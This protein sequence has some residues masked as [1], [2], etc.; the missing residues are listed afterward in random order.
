MESCALDGV[1]VLCSVR[2][3]GLGV[4]PEKR[5]A[6]A[7]AL[8]QGREPHPGRS[9][10]VGFGL[11]IA[12]HLAALMDGTMW[13]ESS[14]GRGST[15]YFTCRFQLQRSPFRTAPTTPRSK[16]EN[17]HGLIVTRNA[18]LNE[19]LTSNLE[20]WSVGTNHVLNTASLL[21]TL[22]FYEHMGL[23][24]LDR[25]LVIDSEYS[26]SLTQIFPNQQ[27]AS[28]RFLDLL[29]SMV[30]E[31]IYRDTPARP[32]TGVCQPGRQQVPVVSV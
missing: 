5:E 18:T 9:G 6:L 7:T 28:R 25:D 16:R 23:F 4:P 15:F 8:Q 13:L 12:S 20:Y 26:Q 27:I 21:G 3:T 17:T 24:L 31:K 11:A 19:F 2:D 14:E 32:G 1:Q 22:E 30:S 10:G 29:K